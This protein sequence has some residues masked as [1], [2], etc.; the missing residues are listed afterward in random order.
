[1]PGHAEL[2]S[3]LFWRIFIALSHT[4]DKQTALLIKSEGFDGI[5]APG[6]TAEALDIL[7]AKKNGDMLSSR[8]TAIM[9]LKKLNRVTYLV[10][11]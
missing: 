3:C 2:T 5:I 10:L 7:K 11:L 1:M 8:L 4:V 9:Y 6:Y